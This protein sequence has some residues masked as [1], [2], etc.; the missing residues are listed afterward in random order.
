MTAREFENATVVVASEELMQRFHGFAE[1]L[2]V[3][4]EVLLRRNHVLR[5]TRD[6]LLPK[7]VSGEVD[8]SDLDIRAPD[9]VE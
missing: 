6:L 3:E 9:A 1:P 4:R 5:R 2:Y 8:V 7:L